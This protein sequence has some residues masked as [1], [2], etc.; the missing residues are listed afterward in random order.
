M[1]RSSIYENN[2]KNCVG[3]GGIKSH[4]DKEEGGDVLSK[5][6]CH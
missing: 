6:W 3:G 2:N 5:D 4:V 1:A